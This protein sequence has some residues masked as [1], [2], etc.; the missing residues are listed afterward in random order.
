MILDY[1][2]Y[3]TERGSKGIV[4]YVRV[5]NGAALFTH[6]S[7]CPFCQKRIDTKVYSNTKKDYPDWLFGS[8]DQSEQVVQCPI[9]GWWEYKYSNQSDAIVDGIRASDIEYSS[10][11]LKKYK[12]DSIEVPVN[13][14]R[15]YLQDNPE[16]IYKINPHKMEELVRSVFADFY[17]SCKV[18]AFGKTRDG[19]KDGLLIDDSGKQF[20]IQVKQHRAKKYTESVSV[21]RELIGVAMIEDNI[22]GCIFVS[23]ADHYSRE[24]KEAAQKVVD[25]EVIERFDL[26]NC[27]DF[28]KKVD[29]VSEKIPS[30]WQKL[31]KL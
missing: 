20:I 3:V 27:E 2:E 24:A 22:S 12:D 25:K 8:F 7:T 9:C 14:L 21:I 4:N 16:V 28:L 31:L 29:L 30:S 10:A 13:V 11:I 19:G 15:E 5:Y 1:S 6:D 17:P 18:V 26:F 23:T